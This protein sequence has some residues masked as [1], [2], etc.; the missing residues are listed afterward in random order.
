M[1]ECV[2]LSVFTHCP[3]D[4]CVCWPVSVRTVLLVCGC[5]GLSV[6][7]C[8]AVL[9]HFVCQVQLEYKKPISPIA[10]TFLYSLINLDKQWLGLGE[11]EIA[12]FFALLSAYTI[13]ILLVTVIQI[14]CVYR[15]Q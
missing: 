9:Q 7:E 6:W 1:C 8:A 5:V 12:V 2:G 13:F 3:T 4:V 14:S 11:R 10:Q 15:G